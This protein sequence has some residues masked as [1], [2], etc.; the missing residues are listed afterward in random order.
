MSKLWSPHT[1][2]KNLFLWLDGKDT[3]GFGTVPTNGTSI[4]VWQDKS[5]NRLKF[6]KDGS[7]NLPTY[8]TSLNAVDFD[9]TQTLECLA[10]SIDDFPV[11]DSGLG[12]YSIYIVGRVDDVSDTGDVMLSIDSVDGITDL[13]CVE[14]SGSALLASVRG[15][16]G[17]LNSSTTIAQSTDAIFRTRYLNDS[18][19]VAIS[20]AV[21]GETG[22]GVALSV[23]VDSDCNIKLM[24][25]ASADDLTHGSIKEILIFKENHSNSK[26]Q[27]VEGY[28]AHKYALTSVLPSDHSYKTNAPLVTNLFNGAHKLNPREPIQ[29]VKM[30]L[31]ECDNIFGVN[32]GLSTCNIASPVA[33]DSCHNTKHSCVNLSAYRLNNVGVKELVFSSEVGKNLSGRDFFGNPALISVTTAPSE[34]KPTKGISVRSNI[35]IRIRD[36]HSTDKDQDPYFI[37]RTIVA[38]E[39]GTYFQKL[40][41]RNPHFFGR[42]IE[43]YDGF[44]NFDGTYEIEDGKRKYIIDS[45]HL[46]SG[47]CTIKCK[48]PL[49]L[50]DELKAKV[51]EP[52]RFSLGESLGTGT[53]SHINLKFDDVALDGSVS[54]D[55]T[56]VTDYFGAD[57]S[58]GFIR[59]NEEIMGYRVDVSGNEAALDITSRT[60][61]GTEGNTSAYDAN[62]SIQKCLAF[63]TYQDSSSG[64]IIGDAVYQ[65][66]VTEAGVDPSAINNATGGVYSWTDEG[67]TWLNTFKIN[68][69]IS[70]PEEANKLVSQLG[71]MVGVNF[72]YDDLAGQIVMKAEMPEF[73]VSL[74]PTITDKDIVEDSVKIL[75]DEKDRVSRVYYYYNQKNMTEDRDKKK[76][77]QNL[78][79]NIDADSEAADEYG[80]QSNKVIYGWGVT[81]SS[82]ATS[83]SQRILNRFK[84]TPKTVSFE[85]DVG[86]TQLQ[87]GDHFFLNTKHIRNLK[88]AIKPLTEMQVVFNK[89]NQVRQTYEIK[90][91]QFRFSTLNI[92]QVTDN[93]FSITAGGSNYAVND[94]IDT[95]SGGS[96]GATSVT[97]KVLSVGASN[98][99]TAIE[100]TNIGQLN[101]ASKFVVGDVLTENDTDISGSGL[102]L[103]INRL[104]FI[105]ETPNDGSEGTGTEE[106]L[107]TGARSD[108]SYIC[109]NSDAGSNPLKMSN[110]SE[111]Y[112]IV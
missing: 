10:G 66:L 30:Y 40:L 47:V 28:L 60:D 63:G 106:D 64:T 65:I 7:H 59:I 90:A 89:Y 82:T 36:F 96:N 49:S 18:S 27:I 37:D 52:T 97:V 1:E 19:T 41:E 80:K 54:A 109:N 20:V 99:V 105:A 67:T 31:D 51:P 73:N 102:Q 69:V 38:L 17:I 14:S 107:Y 33:A 35:T 68:T 79:V 81:D 22:T 61:W 6:I 91:K 48:D 42:R 53:H 94:S 23:N 55:K 84:N 101:T 95:F 85:L 110:G 45:M 5:P 75:T 46:D 43:V 8:D 24:N 104:Y 50:G 103:T 100:I 88:G 98:A 15:T 86:G 56:K 39:N 108:N 44:I 57:D 87:T 76:S 11:D 74:L 16:A 29:I 71:T 12:E 77:Y 32:S 72:F 9:G 58:T 34:I 83:I 111:P 78:Y 26:S 62:D 112:R 92:G 21:N 2:Y 4:D 13:L 3:S 25:K 70:E 93:V